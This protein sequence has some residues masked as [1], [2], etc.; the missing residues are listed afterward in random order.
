MSNEKKLIYTDRAPQVLGPYSQ[1]VEIGDFIFTSGMI[2]INPVTGDVMI[3][4]MREQAT[5]AIANLV[6]VIRASGCEPEDV[7]KTTIYIKRMDDFDV[8]N[9]V[10]ETFFTKS[11][12]ARTCVEVSR[13]PKGALI[14]IDAVIA[15]PKAK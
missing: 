15:K 1:A 3:G 11:F 8:L 4:G 12:P 14:E 13:L 2:P 7:V 6:E 10:Y 5:Q 9:E